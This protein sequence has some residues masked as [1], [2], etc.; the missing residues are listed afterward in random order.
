MEIKRSSKQKNMTT[1]ESKR[2]LHHLYRSRK[3]AH[4]SGGVG[5]VLVQAAEM[6]YV[7]AFVASKSRIME[8][9]DSMAEST[10]SIKS[11]YGI[12]GF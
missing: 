3:T 4:A 2:V 10:D 1:S 6:A 7:L 8:S 9:A 5:I 12:H 11:R